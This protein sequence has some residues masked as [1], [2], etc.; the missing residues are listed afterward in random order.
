MTGIA[1]RGIVLPEA[2]TGNPL[3]GDFERMA[4]RRFQDP[5][6]KRRGDG[7]VIQVRQD[8]VVNG[9][10]RRIN[11]RVRQARRRWPNVKFGKSQLSISDR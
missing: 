4:R 5:R 6:P 10:P 11:K 7:W 8:V 1:P 3:K 9:K 2:N